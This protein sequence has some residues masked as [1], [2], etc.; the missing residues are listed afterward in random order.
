MKNHLPRGV[1]GGRQNPRG[2]ETPTR[3]DSGSE[4]AQEGSA[5][6]G[7]GLDLGLWT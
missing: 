4:K 1:G 5:A 3:L 7:L 6:L 2:L